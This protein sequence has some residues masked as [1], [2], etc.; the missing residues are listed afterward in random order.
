QLLAVQVDAGVV[1]FDA[2]FHYEI[3]YSGV[4]SLR[5]DVP[6]ALAGE[7]RNQTPGVREKTADPQPDD[8]AEGYVAW[9]FAGES[10]FSGPVVIK[11]VWERKLDKLEVGKSVDVSLPHLQPK[12]VDRAWGQIVV[13]KA[14]TIDEQPAGQPEGLRGHDPRHEVMRGARGPDA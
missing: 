6:Q 8:M 1:K 11:L 3:R 9:V 13:S 12:E 2:T 10:E 7:I 14:E 5:I 4:K